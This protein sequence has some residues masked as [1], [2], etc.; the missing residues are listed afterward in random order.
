MDVLSVVMSEQVNEAFVH[1]V[2][3]SGA[4]LV[5][6]RP[7]T[8]EAMRHIR[9]DVIRK[10]I[11]AHEQCKN[12]NVVIK[13]ET[14]ENGS[15]GIRKKGRCEPNK[16]LHKAHVDE[17][18]DDD[19]SLKKKICVDWTQE[20]HE[21]FVN[22]VSQLGEGRCSPKKILD[23]MGVPGLT[24]KQVA[25]HLQ[26][27]RKGKLNFNDKKR[28]QNHALPS[29]LSLQGFNER[30]VGCMPSLQRNQNDHE[31]SNTRIGIN[32]SINGWQTKVNHIN[33]QVYRGSSMMKTS[34]QKNI[35][36]RIE[37]SQLPFGCDQKLNKDDG[38]RSRITK[39][40]NNYFLETISGLRDAG[41]CSKEVPGFPKD[42]DDM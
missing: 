33:N 35:A 37:N 42:L 28:R 36:Q 22:A 30:K 23:L 20:L 18:D 6:K 13:N 31:E 17:D 25:S 5:V 7:L 27:Y 24:R 2:L 40:T 38:F 29:N 15:F 1:E 11:H 32:L 41:Q 34:N 19:T 14:Q 9:Q 10:R 4:F 21:I 39:A 26:K 12:K 16:R 8:I 3:K